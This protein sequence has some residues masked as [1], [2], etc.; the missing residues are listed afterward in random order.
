MNSFVLPGLMKR[1]AELVG[2][3]EAAHQAYGG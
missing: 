3:I 1:R 2:D